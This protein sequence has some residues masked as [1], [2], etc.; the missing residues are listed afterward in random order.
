MFRHILV[1]RRYSRNQF[2]LRIMHTSQLKVGM[3]GSKVLEVSMRPLNLCK[4][5]SVSISRGACTRCPLD[6][7]AALPHQQLHVLSTRNLQADELL[8]RI[9]IIIIIVVDISFSF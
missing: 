4:M 7:P 2:R 9:A 8:R 5:K 3:V 6:R 1:F